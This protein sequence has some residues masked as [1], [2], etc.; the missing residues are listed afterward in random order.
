MRTGRKGFSS[1]EIEKI[2]SV[3]KEC[4]SIKETAKILNISETTVKKYVGYTRKRKPYT[5]NRKITQDLTGRTF[6]T[7]IVIGLSEEFKHHGGYKRTTWKCKCECGN[8]VEICTGSLINGLSVSCGA[9]QKYKNNTSG[10]R[11]VY[12][13]K[14]NEWKA[15]I[16]VDSKECYLGTFK[17][18][19]A[20]IFIRKEAEEQKKKGID[21]FKEWYNGIKKRKRF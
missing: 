15:S 17:T 14:K 20:A 2:K 19:E 10:V 6:G 21:N 18:K 5:T 4:D 9:C 3:Y 7:L 16:V 12:L 1:E 11:G 8:I 13:T